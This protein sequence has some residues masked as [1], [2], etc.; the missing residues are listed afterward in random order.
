MSI[1]LRPLRDSDRAGLR[2]IRATPEVA[3]WWD[4]P[5]PDF[6]FADEPDATRLVVELDGRL[7]GMVQFMQEL[8]PKYRHA[9]ID[10]FLDPA[11]HGRGV[12]T[13][14]VRRVAR[15]LFEE[16]GHHRLTIDPALANLAAIRAYEK[17]GFK[18]VGV[19]RAYERDA[20]GEGWHD[21]LLMELLAQ[22]PRP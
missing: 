5:E 21:A 10:L 7:V 4:A 2:R 12:G 6:P 17:A 20:D 8:T 11:V 1:L 22:D 15:L 19:M 14:V 3:R 18:R 9:S 13:E 16:R